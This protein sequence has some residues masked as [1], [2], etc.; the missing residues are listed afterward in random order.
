MDLQKFEQIVDKYR[1]QLFRYCYY[2]LGENKPLADETINDIIYLLYNKWDTL[3]VDDNIRAWL[4]RAADRIVKQNLKKHNRYYNKFES[5]EAVV[6]DHI[7]SGAEY[8]DEYFI[9]DSSIEDYVEMLRDALPVEYRK[10]FKYRYIEK[11]TLQDIVELTGIPYSSLRLK[12][13]K[14][15][16]LIKAEINKLFK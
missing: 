10:I 5:L 7:L 6:E 4:Y 8:Y 13:S 11:R 9:N 15:E 12:I 16:I 2:R 1:K 3:D 14:I